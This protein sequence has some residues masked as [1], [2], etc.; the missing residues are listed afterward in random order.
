MDPVV[1]ARELRRRARTLRRFAAMI[2]GA[3]LGALGRL[4]GDGTWYGPTAGA[5]LEDCHT[6]DRLIREALDG[7]RHAARR[8]DTNADEVER[9]AL[10]PG[11][12]LGS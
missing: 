6:V 10:V 8:L 3:Q 2:E 11:S 5:F 4:G 1:E 12:V 7:L 9:A